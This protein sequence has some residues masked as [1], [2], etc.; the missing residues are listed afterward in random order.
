MRLKAHFVL[1]TRSEIAF[2]L[3]RIRMAFPQERDR[4][5]LATRSRSLL[6]ADPQRRWIGRSEGDAES[7]A[8]GAI[9]SDARGRRHALICDALKR[10]L[11]WQRARRSRSTCFA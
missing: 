1:A 8:E 7:V 9:P 2:H 6:C 4:L 3:L 10:I 11:F 5:D